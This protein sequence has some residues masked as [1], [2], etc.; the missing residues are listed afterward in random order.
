M[1]WIERRKRQLDKYRILKYILHSGCSVQQSRSF[2]FLASVRSHWFIYT[3][4]KYPLLFSSM[5]TT[6]TNNL[7]LFHIHMLLSFIRLSNIHTHIYTYKTDS[8]DLFCAL[9]T[10]KQTVDQYVNDDVIINNFYL[11][12][13]FVPGIN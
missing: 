8:I 13:F 9:L 7:F 11:K 3:L 5:H 6:T 4:N 2:F 12:W 1:I 10:D